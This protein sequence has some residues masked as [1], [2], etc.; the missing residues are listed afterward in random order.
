MFN[1]STAPTLYDTSQ[2]CLNALMT[3]AC[4]L[5]LPLCTSL[6]TNHALG[7]KHAPPRLPHTMPGLKIAQ[8]L[9][10]ESLA[11]ALSQ[12]CLSRV[13]AYLAHHLDCILL[14]SHDRACKQAN[15]VCSWSEWQNRTDHCMAAVWF[16][17][18]S[19]RQ[20]VREIYN[21]WTHQSRGWLH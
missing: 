11:P 19:C 14:I 1:H 3:L 10:P 15:E 4:L 16:R 17:F 13:R 5:T 8:R 18:R 7:I 21:W 9:F 6:G 20:S 2:H 12:W